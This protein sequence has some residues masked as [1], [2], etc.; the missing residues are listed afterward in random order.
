MS[1]QAK[2]VELIECPIVLNYNFSAGRA[3]TQFLRGMKQGK[4]IGQRSPLTGKVIV[5]PRGGDPESGLP[6]EGEVPLAGV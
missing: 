1:E 5:P 2:K 4:L 6:T 3:P